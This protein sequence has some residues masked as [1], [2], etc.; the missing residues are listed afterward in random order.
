MAVPLREVDQNLSRLLLVEGLVVGAVLL[1]VAGVAWLVVRV[2]LRPLERIGHTAGRIAAGDLSHRVQETD[3]RS[4]VGRLGR[5]STRCSTAWRRPSAGGRPAR[6]GCA[7]SWPTPRTSCARRWPR[8]AATPSSTGSARRASPADV[9]KAMRRIED[10]SARMGVLVEDLLTLARLD[11]VAGPGRTPTST[12]PRWPGTP[13]TT[14]APWRPIATSSCACEDEPVVSGDERQLRQV[15]ANLLRN[16]TVHT[17]R[18]RRS[19]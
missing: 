12:W 10:E 11:Q 16:A 2:G 1:L 6:T 14:R 8:S 19:A 9:N 15:L 4:E 17:A 3:P 7:G 5:R 13:S 18:A